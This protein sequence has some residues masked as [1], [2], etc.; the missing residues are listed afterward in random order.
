M[1]YYLE[2]SS[3]KK[4][5]DSRQMISSNNSNSFPSSSNNQPILFVAMYLHIQSWITFK[6]TLVFG[7]FFFKLII[8]FKVAK[9]T[10]YSIICCFFWSVIASVLT[11]LHTSVKSNLLIIDCWHCRPSTLNN[12]NN[13]IETAFWNAKLWWFFFSR[14]VWS[15]GTN[16]YYF[17]FVWSQT[18]LI[19]LN[20]ILFDCFVRNLKSFSLHWFL[21]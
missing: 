3:R 9:F 11:S 1:G 15:K 6:L 7:T 4:I 13:R 18:Y 12:L 2:Y 20:C 19:N 17:F 5:I 21:C 8:F 14:Y 10:E 16:Y